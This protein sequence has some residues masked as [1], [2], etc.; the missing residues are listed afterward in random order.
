MSELN[1]E[2][3]CVLKQ[4][5]QEYIIQEL[6]EKINKNS[7]EICE[8]LEEI[9]EKIKNIDNLPTSA[10]IKTTVSE[11]MKKNNEA[12]DL[13]LSD[14]A[15]KKF[16][17]DSMKNL[18][19]HLD[20]SNQKIIDLLQASLE[21]PVP[22]PKNSV[23]SISKPSELKPLTESLIYYFYQSIAQKK[24]QIKRIE[25]EIQEEEKRIEELKTIL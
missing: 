16:I 12:Q 10:T 2:T 9:Q 14:K 19:S 7:S 13:V 22:E 3:Q 21:Q 1:P 25:L 6:S 23:S 11:I 18:A 15:L 20:K 17:A 24:S 5:F 8:M 4:I